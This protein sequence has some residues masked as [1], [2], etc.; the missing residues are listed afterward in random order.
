MSGLL[1]GQ[2]SAIVDIRVCAALNPGSAVSERVLFRSTAY[3]SIPSSLM[4]R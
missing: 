3:F 4:R 1:I 2:G